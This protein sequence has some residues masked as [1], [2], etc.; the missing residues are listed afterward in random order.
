MCWLSACQPEEGPPE[1]SPGEIGVL[2]WEHQF[3]GTALQPAQSIYENIAGN[4][5]SITR[6]EYVVSQLELEDAMGGRLILHG[7]WYMNALDG[8]P[9]TIHLPDFQPVKV[10]FLLGMDSVHNIS[11][12]YDALVGFINLAWP[13]LM[14]G[15]YHFLK[16]EGRYMRVG[17]LEAGYAFHL[18]K[19]QHSI[20]IDTVT[21]SLAGNKQWR[22]CMEVM[23]WFGPPVVWDLNQ[24]AN[25]TMHIDSAMAVLCENGRGVF[26]GG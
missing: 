9:D 13:D 5:L 1:P 26:D 8:L 17:G 16:L 10:R 4:T 25:M 2:I 18:G 3:G 6:L 23:D 24:H 7:P 11:N 15:G 14:G 20:P 22:V 21:L 12:R 19:S